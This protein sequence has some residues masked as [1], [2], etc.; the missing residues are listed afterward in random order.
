[1][2]KPI[3]E[4]K[5][6]EEKTDNLFQTPWQQF[7]EK[8]SRGCESGICGKAKS[9]C[10]ARGKV[11]ADVLFCGEAPGPSE[12]V[13]GK[14]F[15]GPA[16]HLLDQIVDKS[17]PESV[18][19]VMTN[20]VGCIP[21]DE[22]G[23]KF[24]EPADEDVKCCTP[25]LVEFVRL[26]DPRLIVCVGTCARDWLDPK[27]KGS[28]AALEGRRDYPRFHRKIPQVFISHPAA[29]LR[30]NVANQGFMMQKAIVTL[31][32]AVTSEEFVSSLHTLSKELPP[33]PGDDKKVNNWP[34]SPTWGELFGRGKGK[35]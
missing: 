2:P 26:C 30:A 18:R 9:V 12:N 16:G 8:W 34:N 35:L 33:Q 29:I 3:S 4:L 27:R 15:C 20:L 11:P 19:W 6:S 5:K 21:L 10:L 1:M 13:L 7:N 32:T 14:P 31:R 17:I 25:R 28:P 24:T 22:Y 23:A